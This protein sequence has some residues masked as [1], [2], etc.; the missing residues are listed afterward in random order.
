MQ[1]YIK[2]NAVLKNRINLVT[3]KYSVVSKPVNQ[4]NEWSTVLS[5]RTPTNEDHT[6]C[7][8]PGGSYRQLG[9]HSSRRR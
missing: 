6:D 7:V 8:H 5:P 2:I 1:S 4:E 3:Y 9:R